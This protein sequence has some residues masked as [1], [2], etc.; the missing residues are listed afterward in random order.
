MYVV[1]D[2]AIATE[3]HVELNESSGKPTYYITGTFSTIEQKNR[4]GRIYP[5]RIW[6]S[7]VPKYKE[8]IKANAV[9]SLLEL[10]HPSD[11]R[12]YVEPTNAVAK[13]VDMWIEGDYV[14]GKAKLLDTPNGLILQELAKN[15][16]PISVSSRG[17]GKLGGNGLVE[18]YSLI[19][20]DV[21]ANPSDYAANLS[22]IQESLEQGQQ[23][24]ITE[25]GDIVKICSKDKCLLE[26][27]ETVNEAV[28]SKFKEMF[29]AMG[30]VSS[31]QKT[32]MRMPSSFSNVTVGDF[33]SVMKML[34]HTD[35]IARYLEIV[36]MI[37]SI[38]DTDKYF[39]YQT[40][41]RINQAIRSKRYIQNIE[42]EKSSEKEEK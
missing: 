39:T 42:D 3:T 8:K 17:L 37:E 31:D 20:Y 11:G 40:V 30:E 26:N 10:E 22:A 21:V 24:D 18:N 1:V 2:E 6:E 33:I 36:D 41:R 15:N 38:E 32:S 12:T 5:R 9:E 14:K 35:K 29:E 27:R 25:T 19:C 16:I 23:Y 28:I 13:M 7:E 34:N 4:N